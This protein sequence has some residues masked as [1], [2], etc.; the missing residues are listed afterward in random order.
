MQEIRGLSEPET[1]VVALLEEHHLVDVPSIEAIEHGAWYVVKKLALFLPA[2]FL[3]ILAIQLMKA[4]RSA[5]RTCS[6][7][8]GARLFHTSRLKVSSPMVLFSCRPGV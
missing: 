1:D 5:E 4:S 7:C 6:C 8:T 2:I 3:F